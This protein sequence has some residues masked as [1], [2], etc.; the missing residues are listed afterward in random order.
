MSF[1]SF[2]RGSLRGLAYQ[3][4]F[5]LFS[6]WLA[7]PIYG[8]VYLAV[9]IGAAV[10]F[11]IL[12]A[13]FLVSKAASWLTSALYALVVAVFVGPLISAPGIYSSGAAFF[14]NW[15]DSVTS[16]V[17]GWKQLITIDPPIGTYHG[18]MT[19]AFIIFFGANL[20]AALAIFGKTKRQWL[21]ILP[22]FAMVF[23]AFA[24]G[25]E[26]I[27]DKTILLGVVFDVPSTFV[28]GFVI[29]MASI[30]FLTPTVGKKPRFDFAS[31][32]NLRALTR[33]TLQLGGSWVLVL[34][35]LLVVAIVLGLNS[36]STREVLR[37]SP[38]P[39]FTGQELSPLS[40]YRQNFTD[41][42]KL[43]SKILSFSSTDEGL[44]RI[45]VAVL[46][47]F[48]GQIFSV[49]NDNGVP[50]AFRLLPSALTSESGGQ[51][52]AETE[53]RLENR[54]SAWLPLVNNVSKVE[55]EGADSQAFGDNF[56]F[57]R[58]TN[59]GALLGAGLPSGPISYKVDS[60]SAG[61]GVDPSTITPTANTV[62]SDAANGE[63]EV[64]QSV[65][66]WID[67][68]DVD[69]SNATGFEKLVKTL[70]ARGYLSH[71]LDEPKTSDS[72]VKKID[73]YAFVSSKAGHAKGR[74]DQMFDDLISL[75]QASKEGVGNSKL[76]AT[77]GDDEQ[78]ATAA[79][80]LARAAGYES[81]VVVG[82]RTSVAPVT[83]GV[84]ACAADECLGGNL[85]A[86]VESS[87]AGSDWL[88]IDV[89]P[90]FKDPIKTTPIVVGLNQNESKPGQ[91]NATVLPPSQVEPTDNQEPGSGDNFDWAGLVLAILGYVAV[92][93]LTAAVIFGPPAAII[94]GKRRRRRNRQNAG[95]LAERITGAWD[96]YVDNLVDLGER[97][98]RRLP[99]NETRPELLVKA[100]IANAELLSSEY[101]KAMVRFTD[102]AAFAPEEPN[103]DYERQVWTFVD[104]E[105][106]KSTA[107]LSRYKRLRIRLSL[108]SIIYRASAPEANTVNFR[109]IGVEG[110]TFSAF[111]VV[112]KQGAVEGFE[113]AKP[114]VA[115]FVDKRL[116]FLNKLTAKV[117][118]KVTGLTKKL[119]RKGES[120]EKTDD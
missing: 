105:F 81:R 110:S 114:R 54:S 116:P 37:S 9:V 109:R 96:E 38:P 74:I 87:S 62:C 56:Y 24:F 82:F 72:W 63:G 85:T 112:A 67:L 103:P 21:A 111:L 32:R 2:D 113:W 43:E 92:G 68:Q 51:S 13:K 102:F 48:N 75:Q 10:A 3:I 12:G 17:F 50:L 84:P 41:P 45:R 65:C 27:D 100:G 22:F 77:A 18:L 119:S 47:N 11:G 90:Q 97:G 60:I 23:F 59:S 16:I 58:P 86:W 1:F 44:E 33:Q 99:A 80:L 20:L 98:L 107:E 118:P 76:V 91:D 94:L 71:S 52:S 6:A 26:N 29:L 25:Q 83:P 34:S 49:E 66:D 7:W 88:P 115:K 15:L 5:T 53:I 55:F 30:K 42:Q 79:A 104:S 4:G 31:L 14:R 95:T 89:T 39:K 28:S 106:A 101:A 117:A 120:V 35:A 57:N 8:D 40:L 61:D 73:G 108:R 70:R 78:F 36:A 93:T 64:P 19:P 46:T 69:L